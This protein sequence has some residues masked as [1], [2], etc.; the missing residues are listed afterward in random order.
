MDMSFYQTLKLHI[1]DLV[2]LSKDAL[3]VHIGLSIFIVAVAILGKGK[4]TIKCLL[5]VFIAA[6][7]ME[8]IDLYDNYHSLGYMRW[9]DSVHDI[10]NTVFWPLMIVIFVHFKLLKAKL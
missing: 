5:P 2:G 7:A 9:R 3:H 1:V 6:L 10:A 8:T 4:V